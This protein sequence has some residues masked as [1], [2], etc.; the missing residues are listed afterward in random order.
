M[1]HPYFRGKQYELIT[2]RELAPLLKSAG[3]R[4]VIE[5]VKEG[6]SG[7]EKALSAVVDAGGR[8]IVTVNPH[9][10]DLSGAGDPLTTLLKERFLDKP[11]ISAGILLKQG[12]TTDQVLKCY[13]AHSAHAPV[14]IHAGF[15]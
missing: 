7:L 3:F 13:K 9:H 1:Y 12:M 4:P 14:L 15:S 2:I 8:A 10:G 5:P 11:G 6:L